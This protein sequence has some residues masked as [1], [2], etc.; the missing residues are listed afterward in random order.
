MDQPLD[1]RFSGAPRDS[2]GGCYM[3]GTKGLVPALHIETHRIHDALDTPYGS[4]N[5]AIIVDVSMDQLNAKLKVGEKRCSAFWMPRCDPNGK[6]A[7]KQTLDDAM[8]EKTSPAKYGYLRQCH[9]SIPLPMPYAV[10]AA[11]SPNWTATVERRLVVQ[12]HTVAAT[13]M[14]SVK[15][16][17]CRDGSHV[18]GAVTS[19]R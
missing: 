6:I 19:G 16:V 4:G 2:C 5:R 7:V 9:C 13:T 11:S 8:A 12:Q 3:D 17:T 10:F 1:A 15:F 14:L 18:L